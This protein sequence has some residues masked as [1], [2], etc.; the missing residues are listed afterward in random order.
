MDEL[1]LITTSEGALVDPWK[2]I[3][4]VRLDLPHY[5]DGEVTEYSDAK[6]RL[7][8]SSPVSFEGHGAHG[9]VAGPH[10]IVLRDRLLRWSREVVVTEG[11]EANEVI[12]ADGAVGTEAES[13]RLRGTLYAF[14]PQADHLAETWIATDIE[15]LD[16]V[17][18][19]IECVST[20]LD[21]FNADFVTDM[22]E[23]GRLISG[24]EGVGTGPEGS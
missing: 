8:L 12:I 5:F 23:T 7:V 11:I 4:V 24:I 20:D 17:R 18:V 16:E 15:V 9:P 10:T 2:P 22:E 6:K 3:R 19:K 13:D 21:E 14:G 1:S